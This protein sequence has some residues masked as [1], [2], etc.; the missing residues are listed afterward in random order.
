M[1]SPRRARIA[2]DTKAARRA[3]VNHCRGKKCRRDSWRSVLRATD[4]GPLSVL[5]TPTRRPRANVHPVKRKQL[6]NRAGKGRGFHVHTFPELVGVAGHPWNM[7]K[8]T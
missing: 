8:A 4:C 7:H 6:S 5:N 1:A 3:A 2:G